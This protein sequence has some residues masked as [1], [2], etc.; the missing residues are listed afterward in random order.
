MERY[1]CFWKFSISSSFGSQLSQECGWAGSE[2]YVRTHITE[3]PCSLLQ[4]KGSICI[5]Q[6]SLA[7][8]S[9]IAPWIMYIILLDI[10]M[11]PTLGINS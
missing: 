1:V 10:D 4:L 2:P 11:F 3:P 6:A 8:E 7:E 5:L 9:L